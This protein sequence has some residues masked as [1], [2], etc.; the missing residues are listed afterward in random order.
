MKKYLLTPMIGLGLCL[1]ALLPGRV[2]N[3]QNAA[4][5]NLT[6]EKQIADPVNFIWEGTVG[7]DVTGQLT[8]QL[9]ALEVTGVIWHVEFDWIID[10]GPQSFT[11]RLTGILNTETGH[12]VMNGKVIQ[13]W[14]LGARV[15][16]EGQLVDAATLGFEGQIRILPRTAP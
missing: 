4:P 16:E 7:G 1:L 2:A 3:A 10:A 14:L 11:A 8:T 9:L 6:F 5:V 12:V 15:H 13:G